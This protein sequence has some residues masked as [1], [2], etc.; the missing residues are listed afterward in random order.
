VIRRSHL[1]K[2]TTGKLASASG[3]KTKPTRT[4]RLGARIE[5]PGLS[6]IE[7]HRHLTAGGASGLAFT[8]KLMI[9]PMPVPP[10]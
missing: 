8:I 3:A 6:R 9:L 1:A 5:G 4:E 7:A 2:K 10:Y